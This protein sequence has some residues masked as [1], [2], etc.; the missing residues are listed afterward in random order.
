MEHVNV[1]QRKMEGVEEGPSL[2]CCGLVMTLGDDDD[3][4]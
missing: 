1:R 3:D 4:K 2:S